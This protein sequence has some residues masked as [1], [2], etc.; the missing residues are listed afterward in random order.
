MHPLFDAFSASQLSQCL[1]AF[2]GSF[3]CPAFVSLSPQ[4]ACS[5]VVAVQSL[6]EYAYQYEHIRQ[7]LRSFF[8]FFVTL[9]EQFLHRGNASREKRR[10]GKTNNIRHIAFNL[11]SYVRTYIRTGRRVDVPRN[12]LTT[13]HLVT[14]LIK[15]L[16][17]L[18]PC[19]IFNGAKHGRVYFQ[20]SSVRTGS[21]NNC[22]FSGLVLKIDS[23]FLQSLFSGPVLTDSAGLL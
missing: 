12:R 14:H 3:F 21:E 6:A 18:V 7:L 5:F 23:F 9:T 22:L 4:K 16:F 2:Y 17:L 20:N 11:H 8:L 19:L 10:D 13:W 1:F 15:H